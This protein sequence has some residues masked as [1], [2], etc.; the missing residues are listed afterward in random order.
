MRGKDHIGGRHAH[1]PG[2][3]LACAGGLACALPG[4]GAQVACGMRA[5]ANRSRTPGRLVGAPRPF[6]KLRSK[7]FPLVLER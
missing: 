1:V 6:P 7:L 4:G 2:R 5:K 3:V